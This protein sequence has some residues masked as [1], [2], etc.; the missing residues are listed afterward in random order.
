MNPLNI[1]IL[2]IR[3]SNNG[4]KITVEGAHMKVNFLIA[5]IIGS[6]LWLWQSKHKNSCSFWPQGLSERFVLSF[7]INILL[8]QGMLI[9]KGWE[10]PKGFN[11]KFWMSKRLQNCT[12]IT[13]NLSENTIGFLLAFN[14]WLKAGQPLS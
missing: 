12:Q 4:M 9:L 3:I 2:S 13:L 11:Y 5:L 10:S 14:T 6:F 7:I 8:V 1:K